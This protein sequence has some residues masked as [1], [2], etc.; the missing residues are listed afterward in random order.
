[1][2]FGGVVRNFRISQ[3]ITPSQLSRYGLSE[4][5]SFNQRQEREAMKDFQTRSH[6]SN[7]NPLKQA[8]GIDSDLS[9]WMAMLLIVAVGAVAIFWGLMHS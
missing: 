5:H 9:G 2:V 8:G 7:D 4:C 1:M 3:D 6:H